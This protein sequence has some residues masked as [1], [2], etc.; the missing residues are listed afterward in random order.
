MLFSGYLINALKY[1]RTVLLNGSCNIKIIKKA[2]QNENKSQK[3][4]NYF[5]LAL[6]LMKNNARFSCLINRS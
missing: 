1:F 5:L 4:F 3:A 2:E 6:E